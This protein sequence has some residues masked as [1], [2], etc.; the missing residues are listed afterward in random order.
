MFFTSWL[1]NRLTTRST[2]R[3]AR[4]APADGFRPRLE[5][6]DERLVLSFAAP[7]SYATGLQP[8]MVVAAD[9]NGDGKPD[10]LTLIGGTVILRLNSGDGTF[11]TAL[12]ISD[13]GQIAT[14]IAVGDVNGDGKPDLVFANANGSNPTT[15]GTL[16][17][18]VTVRLGDGQGK[19]P[20]LNSAQYLFTSA[21]TSIALAHISAGSGMALVA[22]PG[23]GG[24]VY[25]ARVDTHGTFGVP[26]SYSV[27]AV[28][29]G[30]ASCKVAAGDFTGD[31]MDEIVVTGRNS[32]SVL[33]NSGTGSFGAATTYAVGG[34]PAAVA[35]GAVSGDGK[36]DI[37]TA[38]TNGTVSVLAG[39]GDGT[40]GAVQNYAIG[41]P[42]NSVALGDF[43][44]DGHLDIATTGG[45]ETDVLLNTGSGSF[46]AY[47]KVGP[48]GK[49]VAAAD[50]NGDGYADLA[51]VA[52]PS[53]IYV[54]LND[55]NWP[56]I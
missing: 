52:T 6:L 25:V 54:L 35:L 48:A 7:T 12:P 51:E 49:S 17:G 42:A 4:T 56:E 10:L 15:W 18:S 30:L 19:F 53:S 36:L 31:G 26:Q 33:L 13:P 34:T 29:L 24:K 46:A 20:I 5:S 11:G 8:T 14:A 44:H 40:F 50:F 43:N 55:A 1:R 3:R 37:V 47:Q 39:P 27:P 9:V 32:V 2:P 38:N 23:G 41:G 22:V 45:T 16:I 28:P 21:I